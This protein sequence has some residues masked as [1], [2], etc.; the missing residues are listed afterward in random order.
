[1]TSYLI[2][3]Y[4]GRPVVRRLIAEKRLRRFEGYVE[5]TL[6]FPRLLLQIAI[7]SEIPGYVLGSVRFSARAYF[8]AAAIVELPF[9]IGAGYLGDRFLQRDY[10]LLA[11]VALVGLATTFIAGWVVYRRHPRRSLRN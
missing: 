2:G 11:V 7:P 4:A 9:A 5:Q 1:M 8:A 10:A 3:R 6:S